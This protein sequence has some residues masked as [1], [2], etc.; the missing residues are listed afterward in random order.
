VPSER[1]P[2]PG[3]FPRALLPLLERRAA[4]GNLSLR[5]VNARTL[6]VDDQLLR[7]ADTPAELAALARAVEGRPGAPS[8]GRG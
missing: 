5:G 8:T 7:D 3:A 1:I 6:A 2:L 4:G